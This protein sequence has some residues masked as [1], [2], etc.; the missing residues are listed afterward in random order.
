[1][2][3][4]VISECSPTPALFLEARGTPDPS[5]VPLLP[6]RLRKAGML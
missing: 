6:R 4:Q 5:P 3:L 1:M 2:W